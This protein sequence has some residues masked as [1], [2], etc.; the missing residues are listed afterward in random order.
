MK[1]YPLV[2]INIRTYNSA[3]TLE[4]TLQ[5]I[6]NQSYPNI[7]ILIADNYSV[8]K[9]QEIA[10][11]YKAIVHHASKL[12]DARYENYRRSHGVYIFSVD[13]DQVLDE[14]LVEECVH[15]CEH[16]HDALIISEKSIIR[17]GTVI[18]KLIAYDKWL[19]DRTLVLD[20][21]AGAACPRFFR[22]SILEKTKWRK[23]LSI[24]D[25]TILYAKLL[26]HG[27]KVGY[28]TSSHI[29]HYEVTSWRTLYRKFYRYGKGYFEALA[30]QPLA[31][32]THSLPRRSYFKMIA[33]TKPHYFLGLFVLYGVKVI[34]ASFGMVS[35][36]V[37]QFFRQS[38]KI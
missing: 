26:E 9:T 22:K 13:S 3:A 16:D 15:L 10:K 12:G 33:L 17:K 30:E 36:M 23:A 25:D 2:S 11:K 19:I 28:I 7:E 18:E 8:D 1:K 29:R 32:T 14:K 35:S 31:V 5:S 27:A 34:A 38:E 20:T 24:F 6:K 21:I 37:A 4:E